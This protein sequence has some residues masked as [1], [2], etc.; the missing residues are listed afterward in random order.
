MN[1][2][3]SAALFGLVC[4]GIAFGAEEQAAE[5]VAEAAAAVESVT[6]AEAAAPSTADYALFAV[7]N[8]WVMAGGMLVFLMHL[9][10]AC[11]ESGLARAKNCNNILF[12]NTILKEK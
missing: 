1:K 7:N 4:A 12:K 11:V 6:V 2:I 10:F 9:G 8:L 5:A 3:L